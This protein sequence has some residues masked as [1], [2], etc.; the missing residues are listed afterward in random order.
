MKRY[1]LIFSLMF[2]TFCSNAQG[3]VSR[4]SLPG[5]SNHLSKAMFETGSNSYMTLGLASDSSGITY[6]EAMSLNAQ[7]QLLW[8]KNYGNNKFS[9]GENYYSIRSCYQHQGFIYYTG[10]GVDSTGSICGVLL[11]FN[12][13]GDTLWQKVFRDTVDEIVPQMLTKSIDGGFLI[14]GIFENLSV[15][16]RKVM[17]IKTDA[18]GNELWRKKISKAVPNVN[19]GKAIIQDSASKRIAIIGYQ[20]IGNSSNWDT[21]ENLL[22]LDSVGTVKYQINYE[23]SSSG[24]F[25]DL[26]QTKDGKFVASGVL[27]YTNANNETIMVPTIVKFDIN[28]PLSYIWKTNGLDSLTAANAFACV[29]EFPNGDLLVSGEYDKVTNY[30]SANIKIR[31]VRFSAT[32]SVIWKKYYDYNTS[33]SNPSDMAVRDLHVTNDDGWIAAIEVGNNGINPFLFVKYDSTGCDSSTAYCQM[34]AAGIAKNYLAQSNIDLYP[35]PNNG[36][37]NISI[38]NEALNDELSLSILDITGREIKTATLN[39]Q[40]QQ[41]VD[42]KDLSRGVYIVQ[43]QKSH[44]VIYTSKLVRE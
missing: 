38:S 18:N 3:F 35:N 24:Q 11:K 31:Y 1:S 6:L 15:I 32:G 42:L 43:I 13:N 5:Y 41:T 14:T 10:V 23:P 12:Y 33:P 21:Y 7:G 37:L 25:L 40:S 19:D 20:Y 26:I 4:Y 8:T 44:Q 2:W 9:Y 34:I 28:N 22:I 30:L 16:G 27:E 17:L 39:S 29:T 36:L